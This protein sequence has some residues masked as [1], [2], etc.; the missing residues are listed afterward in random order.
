MDI[1]TI[2]LLIGVVIGAVAL[3]FVMLFYTKSRMGLDREAAGVLQRE[4]ADLTHEL[5]YRAD[6]LRDMDGE[7]N[8]LRKELDGEREKVLS[9]TGSLRERDTEFNHLKKRLEEQKAEVEQL[10]EQFRIQFKN[11]ANE[12]L[13]EKSKRFTE[14]NKINIG[15]I[16]NPLRDRIQEFEKKVEQ[17]NKE[18]IDRNAALKEQIVGLKELNQQ[19]TKEAENLTKALKGESKTRG[20]WGEFILESI[21]QKSG[22]EKGREYDIQESMVSDSGK[23]LQ[24]DVVIRLPENKNIVIDSKVSLV[25]YERYVNEENEADRQQ[26]IKDHLN[27]VRGHIKSLSEKNYQQLYG[28]SGL[29]FVLLFMPVEPAFSLAVQNDDQL[30]NNAYD[31]NIVIVS[32]ST[33]IATLR[34][35]ASIWR[36]EKQN[37]Y[38]LEIAEQGGRLYDKFKAF[39]DDLI[40]IGEG[41]RGTK[42]TYD[43]AMNKLSEG[44]DNLIRKSE[45]LKELGAKATKSIDQR[46]LN[47]SLDE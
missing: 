14:Q 10:Q 33:L 16:L 19:I 27:S 6:K 40:K 32:P 11:L 9:L 25:A 3:F 37:R 31:K 43:S 7:I 42:K 34:T 44:R 23:R 28:V 45:R 26:S 47:R 5:K 29:D 1:M 12:I 41:L 20:N 36:Q 4:N 21:L 8:A 24:P 22:L 39:T 15:D 17:V 30:F 13:E 18:S 38:A 46:L 35:I 2:Q